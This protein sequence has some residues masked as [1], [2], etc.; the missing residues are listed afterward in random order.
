MTES[1]HAASFDIDIIIIVP[2]L[3]SAMTAYA[4]RPGLY[5]NN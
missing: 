1:G 4:P 5:R 3:S 2:P